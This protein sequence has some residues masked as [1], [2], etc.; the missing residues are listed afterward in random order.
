METCNSCQTEAVWSTF[1]PWCDVCGG[2]VGPTGK[3]YIRHVAT[4]SGNGGSFKIL[5]DESS[6]TYA[7]VYKRN[8][9]TW[10]EEKGEW[11]NQVATYMTHAPSLDAIIALVQ[12]EARGD[13]SNPLPELIPAKSATEAELKTLSE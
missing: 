10:I 9:K 7:F 12:P 11:R 13:K 6:A 3:H 8:T 1:G 2:V 5:R 4:A